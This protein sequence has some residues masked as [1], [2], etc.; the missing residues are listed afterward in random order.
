[1]INTSRSAWIGPGNRDRSLLWAL[2][3]S[4]S[5]FAWLLPTRTPPWATFYSEA[6]AACA[7]LVV[8]FWVSNLTPRDRVNFNYAV[9]DPTTLVLLLLASIPLLQGALGLLTYGHEAGLQSAYVTAFAITVMGARR[10]Q[11]LSPWRLIE[12]AW[13]GL[14][15]ASV[16]SVGVALCQWLQIDAW[17]MLAPPTTIPGRAV[18]NVG[19][20]NNLS[21][22]LCW[23]LVGIWWGWRRSRIR[24]SLAALAAAY[25]TIGI[26][27]TQSR[28]AW[29]VLFAMGCAAV[30][31]RRQ[32]APGRA[33]V[34]FVFLGLWF[35]ALTLFLSSAATALLVDAP[36]PLSEL[37]TSGLRPVIWKVAVLAAF[38]RPWTGFGWNQFLVAWV[39]TSPPHLPYPQLVSYAHNIVLD[40]LVWVGLPVALAFFACVGV[41]VWRQCQ[42]ARSPEQWLLLVG[43]GVLSV[44]ALLELPHAYAYF[45]FPAAVMIGTLNELNSAPP[46][47]RVHRVFF[48]IAVLCMAS[49]LAVI[50]KDYREIEDH[51]LAQRLYDAR[52]GTAAGPPKRPDALVLKWVPEADEQLRMSP[53][54]GMAQSQLLRWREALQRYPVVSSLYRHAQASLLNQDAVGAKWALDTI[55]SFHPPEACNAARADWRQFTAEHSTTAPIALP[56]V[57][58][59]P[60]A[61]GE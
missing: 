8:G 7:A 46:I 18:A 16:L 38:D 42:A 6:W 19:Q 34:A 12:A 49:L 27:V 43:L 32:L 14:V 21:T 13:S 25:L 1:L 55:C 35:V 51:H 39:Q 4:L 59:A 23:G 9:V 50:V 41:W 57:M 17:G 30:I 56:K 61:P 60:N 44:H 24:G 11:S 48:G 54:E 20:P 10:A 37:S 22:L 26:A 58:P 45:L 31:G 40:M 33:G 53:R 29:P 2:G 3:V 36:R 47:F 15:I 5:A 28:T 52:I